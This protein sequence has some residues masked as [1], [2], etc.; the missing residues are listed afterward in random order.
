MSQGIRRP[1]GEALAAAIELRNLVGPERADH[2]VFAGSIR[3]GAPDVADI[4][5]VIMSRRG[6]IPQTQGVLFDGATALGNLVHFKLDELLAAGTI[7]QKMYR[8][9]SEPGEPDR[10][11]P[12]WGERQRGV[13]HTDASGKTWAHDIYFAD[14]INWGAMLAIRTGPAELSQY[15]VTKLRNGGKYENR[16]GYV[17]DVRTG[18]RMQ[19]PTEEIFFGMCGVPFTTPEARRPPGGRMA[20]PG[21]N[22]GGSYFGR[23]GY[24]FRGQR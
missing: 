15:L 17:F 9:H 13:I 11:A 22:S 2:W 24:P 21:G 23:G 20:G 14:P 19:I 5:H 6:Q 18:E 8:I 1:R 16:D 4:E 7:K 3:R 12:R 10:F